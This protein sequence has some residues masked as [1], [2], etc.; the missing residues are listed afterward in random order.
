MKSS[1]WPFEVNSRK[2]T[3]SK[4]WN[5][6]FNSSPLCSSHLAFSTQK[7]MWLT[8]CF[9]LAGEVLDLLQKC[10]VVGG[11][12]N[13]NK[14]RLG[15]DR[16]R[17]RRCGPHSGLRRP[18]CTHA[19]RREWIVCWG[20]AGWTKLYRGSLLARREQGPW[21]ASR[22]GTAHGRPVC[23]YRFPVLRLTGSLRICLLHSS[24]SKIYWS[25]TEN[26]L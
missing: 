9:V 19:G 3:E 10:G 23:S 15:C 11:C 20:V 17:P 4:T 21:G 16:V 1:H 13:A 7:L 2:Q 5:F 14:R 22:T 8:E 24:C 12:T 6:I 25:D 18:S 26:K